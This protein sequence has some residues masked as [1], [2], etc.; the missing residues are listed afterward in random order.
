MTE[1]LAY[2][3]CPEC[4]EQDQIYVLHSGMVE[5]LACWSCHEFRERNHSTGRKRTGKSSD[6]AGEVR[7]NGEKLVE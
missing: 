1:K 5:I 6:I 7:A 4:Q 2:W 3:K